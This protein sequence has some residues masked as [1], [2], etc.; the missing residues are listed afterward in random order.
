MKAYLTILSALLVVSSCAT[1]DIKLDRDC[2]VKCVK[3]EGLSVKCDNQIKG[4]R[5]TVGPTPTGA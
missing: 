1:K 4:D 2:H 3:C 5:T